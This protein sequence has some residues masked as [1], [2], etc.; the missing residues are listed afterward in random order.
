ME[1]ETEI[2][3]IAS[4]I[5]FPRVI[6][7]IKLASGSRWLIRSGPLTQ[8]QAR[9]DDIKLTFGKRFTKV[10]LHLFLFNDLLLVTKPRRLVQ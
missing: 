3:R 10:P 8:M 2:K 1:R 9:A 5:D 7:S 6:S 4:Q